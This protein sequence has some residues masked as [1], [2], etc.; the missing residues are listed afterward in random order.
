M[1]VTCQYY[2]LGC[3]VTPTFPLKKIPPSTTTTANAL[4]V[5]VLLIAPHL[6]ES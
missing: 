2:G 1:P 5:H 3:A 4:Y 6:P